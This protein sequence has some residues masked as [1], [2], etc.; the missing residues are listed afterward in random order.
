MDSKTIRE[1]LRKSEVD[2]YLF[3]SDLDKEVKS[4]KE[5]AALFDEKK[6]TSKSTNTNQGNYK[7]PFEQRTHS[8]SQGNTYTKQRGRPRLYFKKSNSRF[9]SRGYHNQGQGRTP[10]G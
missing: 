2:K 6:E 9:Q 1:V 5:T 8:N 3:G 7:R 4:L 10:R